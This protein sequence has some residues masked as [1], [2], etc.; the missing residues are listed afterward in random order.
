MKSES[1]ALL[2][3]ALKK[4]TAKQRAVDR[5]LFF[6]RLRCRLRAGFNNLCNLVFY[7]GDFRLIAFLVF[8][9]WGI[10]CTLAMLIGHLSFH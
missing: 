7:D 2:K 9:V 6:Y 3:L 1:E 8:A 5:A 10:I 4:L